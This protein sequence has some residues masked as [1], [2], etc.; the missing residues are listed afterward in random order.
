M[1]DPTAIYGGY[2]KASRYSR[3]KNAD[4]TRA[5]KPYQ[6]SLKMARAGSPSDAQLRTM[7]AKAVVTRY[8]KQKAKKASPA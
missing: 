1:V 5:L 6:L 3:I 8:L 7:S 2:L 4:L